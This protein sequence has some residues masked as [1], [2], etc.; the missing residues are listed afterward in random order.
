MEVSELPYWNYFYGW[1][2]LTLSTIFA[3]VGVQNGHALCSDLNCLELV[4]LETRFLW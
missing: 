1:S 2:M 3:C 4:L